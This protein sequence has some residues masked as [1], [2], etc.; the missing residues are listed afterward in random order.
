MNR[1]LDD[2][3]AEVRDAHGD[4]AGGISVLEGIRPEILDRPPECRARP[5]A[6]QL[7]GSVETKV[8][9]MESGEFVTYALDE[10]YHFAL[11]LARFP[12]LDRP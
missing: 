9:A 4:G 8:R 5:T 10:R 2:V 3:T 11:A 6:D 1:D 7:L 12:G